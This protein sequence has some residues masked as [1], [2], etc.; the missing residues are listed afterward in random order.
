MPE[1]RCQVEVPTKRFYYKILPNKIN[2]IR[3][4]DKKDIF[5]DLSR[6]VQDVHSY[7]LHSPYKR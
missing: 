6:S 5:P 3:K 4:L 2:Q 1:N 7:V